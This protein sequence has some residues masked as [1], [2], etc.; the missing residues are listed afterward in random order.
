MLLKLLVHIWWR[1][2]IS[3]VI[4]K[5]LSSLIQDFIFKR[6][7]PTSEGGTCPLRHPHASQKRNGLFSTSTICPPPLENYS[8]APGRG[9]REKRDLQ[10]R[11]WSVILPKILAFWNY[12]CSVCEDN[13]SWLETTSLTYAHNKTSI[14][15]VITK[16]AAGD[17][18]NLQNNCPDV[19]I[20]GY[21]QQMEFLFGKDM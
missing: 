6:K 20:G 4:R 18:L 11:T 1:H 14:E 3:N 9:G 19:A 16:M 17:D 10:G 15:G 13:I 7:G 12:L 21:H 8:A 2:Y 5:S